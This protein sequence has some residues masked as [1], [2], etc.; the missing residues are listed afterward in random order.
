MI[1][2][3]LKKEKDKSVMKPKRKLERDGTVIFRSND[4]PTQFV[5]INLILGLFEK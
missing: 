4:A 2:K 5:C 1:Q 3:Y